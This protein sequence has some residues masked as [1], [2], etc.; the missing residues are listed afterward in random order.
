MPTS[1]VAPYAP[2]ILKLLQNPLFSEEAA[3][4]NMLLS[5]FTFGAGVFRTYWS[6]SASQ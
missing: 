6:R 4:W 3:V 1:T 5:H 2:V